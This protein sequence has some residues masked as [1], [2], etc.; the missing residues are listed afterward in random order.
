[1]KIGLLFSGQGAQSV[2]MAKTL[3]D[4]FDAV[5]AL[6]KR[7]DEAVGFPLSKYCFERLRKD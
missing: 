3:Y 2:G 6:F 7:A 4:N 5:K 1:M